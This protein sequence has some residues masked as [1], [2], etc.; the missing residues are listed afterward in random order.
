MSDYNNYNRLSKEAY[1]E[2]KNGGWTREKHLNQMADEGLLKKNGEVNS[3]TTETENH[4][5]RPA[6][7]QLSKEE[8]SKRGK[9]EYAG[10]SD[11]EKAEF[12]S[13][14][15]DYEGQPNTARLE[16]ALERGKTLVAVHVTTFG[17]GDES[18]P[19]QI[20]LQSYNLEHGEY[21]KGA[22]YVGTVAQPTDVV[23]KGTKFIDR[24]GTTLFDYNG[25]P[26]SNYE[27]LKTDAKEVAEALTDFVENNKNA[28]LVGYQTDFIKKSLNLMDGQPLKEAMANSID[29]CNV[30]NEINGGQINGEPLFTGRLTINNIARQLGIPNPVTAFE[31]AQFD[32]KLVEK[33]VDAL[34]I[35]VGSNIRMRPR[36]TISL[37]ELQSNRRANLEIS[38]ALGDIKEAISNLSAEKGKTGIDVG[39]SGSQFSSMLDDSSNGNLYSDKENDERSVVTGDNI[40]EVGKVKVPYIADYFNNPQLLNV[41]NEAKNTLSELAN[42]IKELVKTNKQLAE[43]ISRNGKTLEEAIGKN[44]EIVNKSAIGENPIGRDTPV[45]HKDEGER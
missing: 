16:E 42:D 18:Y 19:M 26:L 37:D 35:E 10:K 39:I 20:A 23:S 14:F 9:E 17:Q 27:F 25:C 36:D 1:D 6:Y 5:V 11:S 38:S 22:D 3:L 34:E 29:L 40:R 2:Q 24:L 41:V 43:V 31:K 33:I 13:R 12:K 32:G 28:V 15:Y 8:L 45:K 7:R 44:G 21:V 30:A 4:Y